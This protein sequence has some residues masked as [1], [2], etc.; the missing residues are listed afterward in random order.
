MPEKKGTEGLNSGQRPR[1][2]LFDGSGRE[3]GADTATCGLAVSSP[4]GRGLSEPLDEPYLDDRLAR[5]AEPAGLAIEGLDHPC[6]EV[7]V[8]ALLLLQGASHSG[9]IKRTAEV[10]PGVEILVELLGFHKWLPLQSLGVDE[11][12]PMLLQIRAA[13][14]QQQRVV[15]PS[16]DSAPVISSSVPHRRRQLT[17]LT[18]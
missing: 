6:G 17:S 14:P 7:N 1:R 10:F 12:Q 11:V 13:L 9:Q 2:E 16:N 8:D 5:H 4:A 3:V 15:A 18:P